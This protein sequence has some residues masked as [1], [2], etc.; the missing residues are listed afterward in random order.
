MVFISCQSSSQIHLL[1]IDTAS[2]V[3]FAFHSHLFS[4]LISGKSTTSLKFSCSVRREKILSNPIP[5]QDCGG[6]PYSIA[7]KNSSS[8]LVA[9][10]SHL[11]RACPCASKFDFCIS[12]STSSL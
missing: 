2:I 10:S 1:I 12:G 11:R 9:S 5:S 6:I 4:P 8:P 7:S 3:F